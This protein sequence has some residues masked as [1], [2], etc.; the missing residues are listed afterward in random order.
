MPISI[1][2]EPYLK[3]IMLN[4]EKQD[5]I[6][7]IKFKNILQPVSEQFQLSTT[8]FEA[9]MTFAN[10]PKLTAENAQE[11]IVIISHIARKNIIYTRIALK[12]LIAVLKRFDS[13]PKVH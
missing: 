12:A 6:E 2:I 5:N 1:L 8:D 13:N 4:L 7:E 10:H 11:I 9:L 3:Q